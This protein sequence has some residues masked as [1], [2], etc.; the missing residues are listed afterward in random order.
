MQQTQ[1]KV[2]LTQGFDIR[3][4]A[5]Q[6]L[7][8]RRTLGQQFTGRLTTTRSIRGNQSTYLAARNYRLLLYEV[9]PE[10][11]Y[12]PSSTLRLTAT[13]LRTSKQNTFENGLDAAARGSFDQLGLET[14]VSQVSKRTVT[15]ALRYV[16]VGFQGDQASV[17]G[18]EI[19][20]ALRP[21]NNMTW[22]L[23]LEQRLS[24]G[25]NVTLAYDGRKPNGQSAVHTGRMQVS[26]LF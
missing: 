9:A 23:N 12:Q 16:R 10:L 21:G 24:N 11:S 25:L 7:L 1:Q 4:L 22:N 14:R 15:G 2:L 20:Q 5:S 17:V 26:V 19:L 18:V 6:T 13:Y 8:L 3:N